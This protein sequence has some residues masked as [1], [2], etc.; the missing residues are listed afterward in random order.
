M[1]EAEWK[2]QWA[3]VTGKHKYIDSGGDWGRV[4]NTRERNGNSYRQRHITEALCYFSQKMIYSIHSKRK[5]PEHNTK[6]EILQINL[7][8]KSNKVLF[9]Q[10][11][12][13]LFILNHPSSIHSFSLITVTKPKL[14]IINNWMLLS[15]EVWSQ[16]ERYSSSL[17]QKRLPR[18][19]KAHL[20]IIN[21]K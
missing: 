18:C 14:H 4:G 8:S 10:I 15:E 12:F 1:N 2:L 9:C 11:Y 7:H 17:F 16:K 13:A 6:V 5:N 19:P 3:R 21:I 20:T